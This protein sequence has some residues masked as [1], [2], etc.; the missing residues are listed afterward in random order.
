MTP[1]VIVRFTGSG[2]LGLLSV[3]IEA[4]F[5]LIPALLDKSHR[6]SFLLSMRPTGIP[7][8]WHESPCWSAVKNEDGKTWLWG[9]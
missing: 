6:L 8:I 3:P 5:L 7:F 1:S 2:L 9:H 4:I